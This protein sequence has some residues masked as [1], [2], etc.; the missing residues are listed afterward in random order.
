M[1]E[2]KELMFDIWCIV[3]FEP[4]FIT[5]QQ[6]EEY[7]KEPKLEIS[8]ALVDLARKGYKI[9]KNERGYYRY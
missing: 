7:L 1:N 6:L 5:L 8:Y 4:N 2:N 3:P 9:N